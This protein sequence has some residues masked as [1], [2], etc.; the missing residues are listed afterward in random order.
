M[1]YPAIYLMG[2]FG[3]AYYKENEL[4][5]NRDGHKIAFNIGGGG[6]S[7]TAAATTIRNSRI[8]LCNSNN[9]GCYC[10]SGINYTNST[11]NETVDIPS[12]QRWNSYSAKQDALT[13]TFVEV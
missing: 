7:I 10:Q 6:P 4:K 3:S 1:D 5:L 9:S 8:W 2:Q 12:I 11:A 13:Y